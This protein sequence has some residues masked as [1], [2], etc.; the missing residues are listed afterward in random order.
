MSDGE[1]VMRI[2]LAMR[3]IS[4]A[5]K[6]KTTK[7]ELLEQSGLDNKAF[8]LALNEAI[9][10]NFLQQT[11][12]GHIQEGSRLRSQPDQESIEQLP[13]NPSSDSLKG[14]V[15][16]AII[17][18]REDEFEAVLK[19]FAPEPQYWGE[20]RYVINRIGLE[21]DD[22]YQVAIARSTDP[23]EGPAQDLAR[24]M[25]EHLAPDWLLVVGIAGGVP[26]DEF[27]LGDVVVAKRLLD[28]SVKAISEGK[29]PEYDVRGWAHPF[30]ERLC[31]SLPA[32]RSKLDKIWNSYKSIG[33]PR[34]AVQLNQEDHFYGDDAWKQKVKTSLERHFVKRRRPRFTAV[35]IG[36]TEELVKSP[37][38]VELW[39]QDARSLRAVEM[40]LAGVYQAARRVERQYP[41]LA[42]RGISDIVGFKRDPGWTT[43]AC[44]SAASF[45]Y[46]LVRSGFIKPSIA[47]RTKNFP[48]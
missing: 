6:P 30:V 20:R 18:I 9:R 26:D 36:A 46:A 22:Y 5:G 45:A 21:G 23:G 8:D 35:A 32:E 42:I 24:D 17:T 19:R 41:V 37:S 47:S 48:G 13:F 15:D 44:H 14:K 43:Y 12:D 40:E 2:N 3:N 38:L 29:P 7:D 10:L 31:A 1:D 16:F 34:P 33:K 39:L 27:S 28:F 25:I 4:K 11:K